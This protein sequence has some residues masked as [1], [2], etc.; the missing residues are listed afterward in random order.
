[1]SSSVNKATLIGY[2]GAKPEI[3][4]LPS[5]DRV[6][7]FS[8]ATSESWKDKESGEK[9]EVTQW[10]RIS[11]FNEGLVGVIEKYLEKGKVS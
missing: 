2:L 3:R 6:A 5:E 10:H 4:T 1:M 11:V 8:V 7:T 9:K